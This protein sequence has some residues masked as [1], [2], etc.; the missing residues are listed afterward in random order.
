VSVKLGRFPEA[1]ST[2]DARRVV[3]LRSRPG[4][5]AV[6]ARLVRPA[7]SRLD[8]RL[9]TRHGDEH[10]ECLSRMRALIS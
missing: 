5:G 9:L 1:S 6:P 2:D 8:L 3:V 7:P 4:R 10:G